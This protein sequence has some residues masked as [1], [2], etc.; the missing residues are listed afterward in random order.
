MARIRTQKAVSK[1][2]D[3]AY[4]KRAHPLRT[5][6]KVLTVVVGVITVVLV[7]LLSLGKT[8]AGGRAG[9]WG[10]AGWLHNPGALTSAHAMIQHDCRACHDG[11]PAGTSD[12]PVSQGGFS[13]TISDAACLKCHD[14]SLHHANQEVETLVSWPAGP[15]GASEAH[16]TAANCVSCHVEHR[17]RELLVASNSAHCTSCHA[18]LKA[19]SASTPTV[20]NRVTAFTQ[21]DHPP[22]GRELMKDGKPFDPTVIKFNHAKHN[23][24]GVLTDNC[25]ACHAP[26]NVVVAT[27]PPSPTVPPPYTVA[28]A[29]PAS[30]ANGQSKAYI[31]PISYEKHCI[32]CHAM[33]LPGKGKIAIPH[34]ELS[35][36]RGYLAGLREIYSQKLAA[37]SQ[38]D[39]E[40]ELVTERV[41]GR[42]PRQRRIR[43]VL[44]EAEWIDKRLEELGVAADKALGRDETYAAIK[45]AVAPRA[46]PV[47]TAPTAAPTPASASALV[48]AGANPNLI[49]H[50]VT[51]GM[52]AS[53]TYCHEVQGTVPALAFRTSAPVAFTTPTNIP[54]TPRRWFTNSKFDHYAHRSVACMDCHD[55][56]ASSTLTSD[57]NSPNLG[58]GKAS[59]VSCHK[60]EPSTFFG[61]HARSAP[62]DCVTCHGFHSEQDERKTFG[63]TDLRATTPTTRPDPP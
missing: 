41:E 10:G 44:S 58:E 49:E 45:A 37:M 38:T 1:R 3:L 20:A 4:F 48:L 11:G 26:T 40:K 50:F 22:F 36:V 24:V 30:W 57:L 32:G 61:S 54:P 39:R 15:A 53:C 6:R 56:A 21:A 19:N 2:I 55:K 25:I 17:G 27:N 12:L 33:E 29:A 62:A 43:V 52:G 8:G 5:G 60:P 31:E 59:C 47:T 18:D 35:T 13:K 51:H 7:G 16:K 28:N 14:G 63:M 9:I 34:E 46:D 23:K 42:P